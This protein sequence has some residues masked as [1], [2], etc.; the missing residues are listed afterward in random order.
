MYFYLPGPG[1]VVRRSISS[2]RGK[3]NFSCNFSS[4]NG[5]IF[6][7]W[8]P[9][10]RAWSSTKVSAFFSIE[11]AAGRTRME[12]FEHYNTHSPSSLSSKQNFRPHLNILAS[13]HNAVKRDACH[14]MSHGRG[15]YLSDSTADSKCLEMFKFLLRPRLMIVQRLSSEYLKHVIPTPPPP[16]S[17]TYAKLLLNIRTYCWSHQVKTN[18]GISGTTSGSVQSNLVHVIF[19]VCSYRLLQINVLFE[20]GSYTKDFWVKLFSERRIHGNILGAFRERENKQWVRTTIDLKYCWEIYIAIWVQ[21]SDFEGFVM[22]T[23]AGTLEAAKNWWRHAI[24]ASSIIPAQK[25]TL[26]PQVAFTS[27]CT[28]GG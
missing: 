7:S 25:M 3:V 18:C 24:L 5:S 12:Q 20:D 11:L 22:C 4:G 10:C 9:R 26:H 28:L 19:G 1:P 14:F 17:L 13:Q 6:I 27:Y 15:A 23:V 2:I 21:L 8:W 16:P